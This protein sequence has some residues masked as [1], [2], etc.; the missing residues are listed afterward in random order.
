MWLLPSE[1]TISGTAA[2]EA[3]LDAY[4]PGT[5][6]MTHRTPEQALAG[7]AAAALVSDG[8]LRGLWAAAQAGV[9]LLTVGRPGEQHPDLQLLKPGSLVLVDVSVSKRTATWAAT[10]AG[11]SC[12]NRLH[13]PWLTPSISGAPQLLEKVRAKNFL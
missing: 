11:A 3:A 2:H 9:P 4:P 6:T 7:G 13:L 12:L 8:G 1:E 5:S 10:I